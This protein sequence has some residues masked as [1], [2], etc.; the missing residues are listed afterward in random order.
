LVGLVYRNGPA[1]RWMLFVA[2][3]KADR[4]ASIMAP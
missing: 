2:A 1:Y 3:R 4:H